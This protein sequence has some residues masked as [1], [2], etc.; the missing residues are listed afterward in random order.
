[1]S[2][3][4]ALPESV[5]LRPW[6]E[7]DDLALLEVWGDPADVQ[8]HQ[9]RAMLAPD[10]ELPWRRALVAEE[11]G[12]AVAA[13]VVFFSRVHPQRLWVYA[14]I[15]DPARGRGIGS[16][17]LAGLRELAAQA[18][19]EGLIPTTALKTRFAF[20]EAGTGTERFLVRHGFTPIQRSRRVAVAPGV[21]ALPDV[22]DDE[23]PDGVVLEEAATGSVELTQAVVA[24]YQAT[25]AWDPAAMTVG[26]A[27]QLLLGPE[28]GASGA[29]VLRDKPKAEGGVLRAFAVSYTAERQD[30]PADVLIGWDPELPESDAQQAVADL[31]ALLVAQYP[32]Q[33]EVDEAMGALEP[34]IDALLASNAARTL[35]DTRIFADDADE[36]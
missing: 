31:L 9:D 32:V 22:R 7:G 2:E 15:A 36:G 6:R 1:M 33:V 19:S 16:G 27:Q 21:V 18:Y 24:F 13:G 35:V 30:D 28:T 8:Q 10:A 14:E 5:R 25:H 11:D 17:L 20:T 4:P 12:V 29:V 34:I 3:L 26:A 23:H